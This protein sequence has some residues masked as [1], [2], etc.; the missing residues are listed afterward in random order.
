MKFDIKNLYLIPM[1]LFLT[2][3]AHV[4]TINFC[5]LAI[6]AGAAGVFQA[7]YYRASAPQPQSTALACPT[8]ECNRRSLSKAVYLLGSREKVFVT[9]LALFAGGLIWTAIRWGVTV[10]DKTF[11]C[12]L[13]YYLASLTG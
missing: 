4:G 8:G 13:I 12:F 1:Y 5:W 11:Y 7:K 2:A 3:V 9:A 10:G 6:A